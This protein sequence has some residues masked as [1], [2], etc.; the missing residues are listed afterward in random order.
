M[1]SGSLYSLTEQGHAVAVEV[2]CLYIFN[3]ELT[4]CAKTLLACACLGLRGDVVSAD[5][6]YSFVYLR[7]TWQLKGKP[8]PQEGHFGPKEPAN[9]KLTPTFAHLP[10][11]HC[12][13]MSLRLCLLNFFF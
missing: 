8:E 13:E 12:L 7:S 5:P 6:G 2:A 4:H 3:R 10:N 11:I 1:H 9:R